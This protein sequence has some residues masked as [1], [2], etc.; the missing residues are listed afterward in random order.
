VSDA[1]SAKE[2]TRAVYLTDEPDE[3]ADRLEEA[4]AWCNASTGPEV[5][6]LGKT[7][8]RWRC[9]ILAHHQTGA[10]NGPTEA[11]N[12]TIKAVKRA[13]FTHSHAVV[14]AG[15]TTP[16]TWR[17][18]VRSDTPSQKAGPTSTR[19]WPPAARSARQFG[20]LSAK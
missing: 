15:S 9:E 3:A 12:L 17:P 5:K 1:W 13:W 4:I 2:K 16:F 7:L 6:R 19:K 18:S 10:S 20:R 11:V 8:R 14:T